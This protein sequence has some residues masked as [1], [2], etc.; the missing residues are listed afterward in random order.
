MTPVL[1]F[2][3]GSHVGNRLFSCDVFSGDLAQGPAIF[4]LTFWDA[5]D[6]GG[7]VMGVGLGVR[8]RWFGGGCR[9]G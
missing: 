6:M 5:M 9:M 2:V 4:G 8:W 1:T 7:T 3:F